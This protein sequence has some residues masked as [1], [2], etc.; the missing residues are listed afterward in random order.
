MK[1]TKKLSFLAL[2]FSSF[3]IMGNGLPI[4]A[5]N[6]LNQKPNNNLNGSEI[7]TDQTLLAQFNFN[8][9]YGSTSNRR[10]T[11][12]RRG[13]CF[14]ANQQVVAILPSEKNK[15]SNSPSVDVESVEI[16]DDQE[17]PLVNIE[18]QEESNQIEENNASENKPEDT[19]P[20]WFTASEYPTVY[21][22]LPE[23]WA[24][25]AR[26]V[27]YDEEKEVV[28]SASIDLPGEATQESPRGAGVVEVDLNSQAD[29]I[30]P[31]VAG[32]NYLWEIEIVCSDIDYSGNPLI[33]GWIQ[34]ID[35]DSL[36]ALNQ[37]LENVTDSAQKNQ[38]YAQKGL[39][40]DLVSNIYHNYNANDWELILNEVGSADILNGQ[41]LGSAT[42]TQT[43]EGDILPLMENLDE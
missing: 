15:V 25:K 43:A 30:S 31:L 28:Y 16:Q 22:Y 35:D 20:A 21:F 26:F 3:L 19:A 8:G 42:I 17:N 34:K 4:L 36:N 2:G 23:N 11:G 32:N 12:F 29:Q 10:T 37:D 14:N 40:Y 39:W 38:I 9:V 5:A 41:I 7:S 18:K 33:N 6:T 27:L 1:S 13:G 24:N